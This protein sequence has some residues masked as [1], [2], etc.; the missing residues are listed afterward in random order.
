[1]KWCWV[2]RTYNYE[3][4]SKITQS[5]EEQ[6]NL[7][8]LRTAA[9]NAAKKK[10]AKEAAQRRE[11]RL[12]ERGIF[13]VIGAL[14]LASPRESGVAAEHLLTEDGQQALFQENTD[15]TNASEGGLGST[16]ALA[17]QTQQPLE[18][19]R[20]SDDEEEEG[21]A[22][23]MDAAERERLREKAALEIFSRIDDDGSGYLDPPELPLLLKTLGRD[24]DELQ[25]EGILHELDDDGDGKISFE[26]FYAW[27]YRWG[28]E[29][30]AAEFSD[31]SR[32]KWWIV[33]GIAIGDAVTHP[34]RGAGVV[35]AIN[36]D[37]DGRIHVE[38]ESAETDEGGSGARRVE[39]HRY[40][41]A[42]WGKFTHES[43]AWWVRRWQRAQ[44]TKRDR[45]IE[46][47]FDPRA[48]FFMNITDRPLQ[49]RCAPRHDAV[50]LPFVVHPREA[51]RAEERIAVVATAANRDNGD[52]GDGGMDGGSGGVLSLSRQ[53]EGALAAERCHAG[54][55]EGTRCVFIPGGT[56]L[57]L[58]DEGSSARGSESSVFI[59]VAWKGGAGWLSLRDERGETLIRPV[60]AAQV[61]TSFEYD[62]N[63]VAPTAVPE[64]IVGGEDVMYDEDGAALHRFRAI[65]ALC[66]ESGITRDVIDL[67]FPAAT[68]EFEVDAF[69]QRYDLD[70]DGRLT[71]SE[72]QEADDE[73]RKKWR[74]KSIWGHFAGQFLLSF[75]SFLLNYTSACC[76][77]AAQLTHFVSSLS[78]L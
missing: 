20:E 2:V 10:L 39:V 50:A 51:F 57:N 4:W 3:R 27:Y 43:S 70:G 7:N 45:E 30:D 38:F 33:R 21:P 31:V 48:G 74:F 19:E 32:G 55:S 26:E 66:P 25:L 58:Q 12:R 9:R 5:E 62:E 29:E 22:T 71:F 56:A 40:K 77:T 1:M 52:G 73:V 13:E 69:M 60:S 53:D 14:V 49:L 15:T 11:K 54:G 16:V 23:V 72:Y 34:T 28:A 63:A 65:E 8:R 67:I 76:S 17:P 44:Q 41:Q 47:V 35:V 78:L 42:S 36:S 61:I 75:C 46:R 24:V 6:L 64:T 59:R 18:R 37:D 68:N